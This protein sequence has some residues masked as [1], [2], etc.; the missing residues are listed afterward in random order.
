VSQ[1]ENGNGSNGLINLCFFPFDNVIGRSDASV[2]SLLK[3]INNIM[4]ESDYI[5]K[6]VPLAWL[7]AVDKFSDMIGDQPW[8]SYDEAFAIAISCGVADKEVVEMLEFLHEMGF[9]LWNQDEQLKNLI[10]LDPISYFVQPA[11]NVICKH[12]PT[13]GDPTHHF[14]KVHK[15]CRNSLPY[16]WNDMIERGVVSSNLLNMLLLE[17][18]FTSS[19]VNCKTMNLCFFSVD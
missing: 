2:Q 16:D 14:L 19:S 17:C 8:L 10:I 6:E 11:T 3:T 4:S 7:Q 12:N 1:N 9:L 13:E 18:S 15:K 5:K